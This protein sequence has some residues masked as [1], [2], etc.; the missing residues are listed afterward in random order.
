MPLLVHAML[1]ALRMHGAAVEHARLPDREIGDIDHLL[2]L[3]ERLGEDLAVLE[4]DQL[5]E[6]TFVLPQLLGEQAHQLAALR[7]RARRPSCARR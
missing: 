6:L 7:R 2:H 4:R 1:R 5:A 3:A